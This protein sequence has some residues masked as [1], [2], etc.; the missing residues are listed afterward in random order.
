MRYLVIFLLFFT[1]NILISQTIA[2]W[3]FDNTPNAS[4]G[5]AANIGSPFST[6]SSGTISY[7]TGS[8]GTITNPPYILNTVWSNGAKWEATITTVGYQ[9]LILNFKQ[10]SSSTGPRDWDILVNGSSVSSYSLGSSTVGQNF[11]PINLGI[12]ANNSP[13]V[14]ITFLVSSSTNVNGTPIVSTGTSG[15]DDVFISGIILPVEFVSFSIKKI[16]N[17]H[18]INFATFSQTNNEYFTIER[19]S[20]GKLFESIGRKD[21]AGNSSNEISYTFIDENPLKGINYY[22]IKQTDFDG[23]YSY[24]EVRSVLHNQVGKI[25][26]N[27]GVTQGNIEIITNIDSYD[28]DIFNTNGLLIKHITNLSYKQNLSIENLKSGMYYIQIKDNVTATTLKVLKI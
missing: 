12:S 10:R 19:S 24:S 21:G 15:L 26:I 22:R 3:T 27:P 14:T 1:Q 11:G 28:V 5:I 20:D 2:S 8:S 16:N 17:T 13:S 18:E 7:P 23:K 9:N 4:G 6:T 25:S